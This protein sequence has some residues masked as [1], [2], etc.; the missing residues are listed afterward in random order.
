MTLST[1]FL[2]I[3]EARRELRAGGKA[4]VLQP[5]VFDLLVYLAHHRDRVVPKRE[6]LEAVWPDVV[7]TDASL[8]RAIS[9]ARAALVE[10]GVPETIRTYARQGYRF[11]SD[12]TAS[13]GETNPDL[14]VAPRKPG[15]RGASPPVDDAPASEVPGAL[16]AAR[17]AYARGEWEVAVTAFQQLDTD[18]RG[19]GADDLQRWA[20]AAQCMG[21]PQQAFPALERAV[22]A[23]AV[24]GS[25][26]HA[27]WA[28]ILC[29]HLRVEWGEYPVANGWVQRAERLL[30]GLPT[31]R[32]HGYLALLRA[33]LALL[34]NRLEEAL[35]QGSLAYQTGRAVGDPDLEGLGLVHR[36][37]AQ[38]YLGQIEDGLNALDEAGVSVVA[39]GLSAWAGGLVY[40]GVI[41]GCMTRADWQRATHLRAATH[42]FQQAGAEGKLKQCQALAALVAQSRA[43]PIAG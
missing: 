26:R 29:A 20:H 1:P 34:H 22:A 42:V 23:Y 17:E 18:E 35:E 27:A 16:Q 8:Q 3:D 4:R 10:L 25:R 14:G 31:A 38:L 5:K 19:L 15:L 40:C 7:V 13:S 37:E 36:G 39:N 2:E 41:F 11:C 9:L 6:L 24:R 33:R 30:D 28:A 43:T 12:H 21:E 32:E